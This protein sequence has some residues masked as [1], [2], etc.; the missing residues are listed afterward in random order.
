MKSNCSQLL[1]EAFNTDA[2]NLPEHYQLGNKKYSLT[3]DN[4]EKWLRRNYFVEE[5]NLS[6]FESFVWIV[7]KYTK[8]SLKDP[9]EAQRVVKK[10][11]ELSRGP[12]GIEA[13]SNKYNLI[14][15]RTKDINSI[16]PSDHLN[17]QE[18]SYLKLMD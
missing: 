16:N 13:L 7:K 17:H 3:I 4:F 15:R 2:F 14:S 18:W 1:A 12:N 10:M 6:V 9:Q 8:R 11:E 5:K